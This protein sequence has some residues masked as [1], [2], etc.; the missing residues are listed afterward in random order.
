MSTTTTTTNPGQATRLLARTNKLKTPTS[1]LAPRHI[2]ANL[3]ILPLAHTPSFRALCARNPVPCPLLAES[4]TPGSFSSLRSYIPGVSGEE[5][6]KDLDIRTDAPGYTIYEDGKL[7]DDGDVGDLKDAWQ[8]DHVAFLVGCSYSFEAALAD[9][10]LSARHTLLGRNVPMYRTSV[11]LWPAG[12]FQGG[13]VVVSMRPYRVDEI[14]RVRNVTER[15]GLMH[16]GP[17]A[18]GWEAAGRLGIEDLGAP[19]WG[20]QPKTMK[21]EVYREGCDETVPVFWGC[22]VTPQEAVMKAG[23]EGRV[24]GH[25]PGH[26]LVLDVRD[27]DVFRVANGK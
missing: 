17:V 3:L 5:I 2:Q 23:L 24:M 19:E 18:W 10:G 25:K 14:E 21:G 7:A 26:M 15:F 6:A 16:G 11:P 9:A 13:T 12:V 27:E 8:D 4:S 22:G 20:D 1:G